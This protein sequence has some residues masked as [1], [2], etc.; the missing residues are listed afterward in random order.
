[1]GYMN[2]YFS[3]NDKKTVTLELLK[4]LRAKTWLTNP[5]LVHFAVLNLSKRYDERGNL[6]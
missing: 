2:I 6:V 5:D 4:R 3:D 1:M